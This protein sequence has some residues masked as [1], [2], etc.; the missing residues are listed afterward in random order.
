MRRVHMV[1]GEP[2]ALTQVENPTQAD[3]VTLSSRVVDAS[4]R[5]GDLAIAPRQG[6][7]PG[8]S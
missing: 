3:L 4:N 8:A 7:I 5:L 6:F 2:I 1:F